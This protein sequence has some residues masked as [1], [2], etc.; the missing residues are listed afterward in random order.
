MTMGA[1]PWALPTWL[2]CRAGAEGALGLLV[3]MAPEGCHFLRYK[4]AAPH[5]PPGG[6]RGFQAAVSTLTSS[7]KGPQYLQ[8]AVP[9][10]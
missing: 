8:C 10:A 7:R 4:W 2:C 5:A 6:A 1:L 3:R 9:T